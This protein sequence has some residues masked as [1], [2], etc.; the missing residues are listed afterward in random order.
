MNR[1]RAAVPT[2]LLAAVLLVAA[3]TAAHACSPLPGADPVG[4][5]RAA[6]AR[7]V[8]VLGAA[9]VGSLLLAFST[10]R[11]RAAPLVFLVLLAA[12]P[13][14]RGVGGA[15]CGSGARQESRLVGFAAAAVCVAQVALTFRRRPAGEA[16]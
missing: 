8:L 16:T 9:G 13:H 11:A 4:D 6:V 12:H 3:A 14:W 7:E 1:F 5:A 15:D 10:R 2:L